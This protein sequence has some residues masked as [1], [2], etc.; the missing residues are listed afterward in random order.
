M[1]PSRAVYQDTGVG[2]LDTYWFQFPV[3]DRQDCRHG[4]VL[5]Y[6]MLP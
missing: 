6:F 5:R 3:L 1:W 2:G 4:C